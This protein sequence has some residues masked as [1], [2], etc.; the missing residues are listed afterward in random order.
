MGNILSE[1]L[2]T[3][4][5]EMLPM[6]VN[7]DAS[8]TVV[9]DELDQYMPMAQEPAVRRPRPAKKYT[10]MINIIFPLRDSDADHTY[11]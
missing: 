1:A 2:S 6:V 7:M 10:K 11:T 8:A 5:A 3:D 4:V 9:A